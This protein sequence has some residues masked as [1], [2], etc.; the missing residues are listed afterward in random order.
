MFTAKCMDCGE[1]AFINTLASG[2]MANDKVPS[3]SW[4]KCVDR[5]SNNDKRIRGR[6]IYKNLAT[7]A[8]H[9]QHNLGEKHNG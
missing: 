6:V 1:K 5:E 2:S 8:D 3:I 7:F 9:L 4:C